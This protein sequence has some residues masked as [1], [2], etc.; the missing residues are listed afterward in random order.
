MKYLNA[1]EIL[2]CTYLPDPFQFMGNG[3]YDFDLLLLLQLYSFFH[4]LK[5]DLA[6]ILL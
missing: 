4:S 1:P 3:T 5:N 6:I 2:R